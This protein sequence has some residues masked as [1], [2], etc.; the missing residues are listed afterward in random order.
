MTK[1]FRDLIDRVAKIDVEAAKYLETEVH[2]LPSFHRPVYTEC[3][4][5]RLFIWDSSPQGRRY[6]LEINEKLEEG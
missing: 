5:P 4:L 3:T 2:K 6:W 1:E